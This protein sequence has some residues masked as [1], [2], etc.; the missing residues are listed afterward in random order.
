MV[1]E[2][3][4]PDAAGL[5]V[6]ES[7]VAVG[8]RE[9]TAR[10][11]G[12]GC[13]I[14][15][16]LAVINVYM[17]LKT[18]WWES[19]CI[20]ASVLGFGILSPA[21]RRGGAPYSALEN[22]L[23]QTAA[24]SVGAVPAAAGLLGA[25]PA[26][27]MLGLEIPGWGVAAWGL[28]LG[29]L[30]VL[31]GFLLRRRLIVEEGLPFPT[32]AATAE[33]IT[34]LHGAGSASAGRARGLLGVGAV[35]AVV[36]WLRDALG[37]IPSLTALPGHL[38]GLPAGTFTLGV[39]WS[40]MLLGI[41]IMT[42]PHMGLSMLL[43]A[44]VA[45]VGLA[46]WL[47]RAGVVA[48]GYEAFSAWLTW[49]GVGMMV[50]AAVVGLVGQARSF[51]G[52]VRDVRALGTEGAG[53]LVVGIGL[54]AVLATLMLS[55]GLFGLTLAQT[56]L[57]LALLLPLCAVCARAAGQTD[58][59]PVSQMGQLTQVATGALLPG[60]VAP[61]VAAGSVVAG[62]A[63]HTGVCMWALK[64]GHDLKASPRSQLIAQLVGVGL[65]ALVAVP[66][67]L[68]L[69]RAWPLGSEA[70]PVPAAHGF[71]AMAEL[72]VKGLAGLPPHAA[73]AAG[74][75]CAVGAVLALVGRGRLASVLPS[76]VAM[77]IGFLMPA[78]YAVTLCVGALGMALARKLKPEATERHAS[79]LGAG[80]IAG[81]SLL[82]VL[83]AA[84]LALGVM[85]PG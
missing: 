27:A 23:T 8:S 31:A 54:A 76:P 43:G 13:A 70:L 1:V 71:R 67:Y 44:L 33:L 40:P 61:N 42:G 34:T 12:A 60:G 50:G 41:G 36:T 26:L 9:L 85:R 75:G 5:P 82:A 24:S 51:A 48:G 68:L 64:A 4:A 66:A 73:L 65:G 59:S 22:N 77:G 69:V 63:A 32:G 55:M 79:A 29:A 46:P 45:W 6:K 16:L 53:R 57:V 37:W 38:G 80:A 28:A 74:V 52:A 21:T 10:A 7:V 72:S 81:E 25:L 11:L 30:G 47:V 83:V 39:A 49:P 3:P 56:L 14:G 35:A 84:L 17:G 20:L 58:I 19:G 18:S 78:A 15:A 62:A 2:S